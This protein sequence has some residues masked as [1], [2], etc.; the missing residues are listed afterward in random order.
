MS[1]NN[2]DLDAR[3]ADSVARAVAN[4]MLRIGAPPRAAS[5]PPLA[6]PALSPAAAHEQAQV[7][8]LA[9]KQAQYGGIL[10]V[11]VGV[12]PSAARAWE[13]AR[14]LEKRDG[15]VCRVALFLPRSGAATVTLP[16]ME[17]G[18]R[19]LDVIDVG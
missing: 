12:Y 11:S 18:D 16:I 4:E 8:L 3:I 13:D 15:C 19:R 5:Q 6:A 14:V 9:E 17:E 7:T 2:D 1:N 10:Y